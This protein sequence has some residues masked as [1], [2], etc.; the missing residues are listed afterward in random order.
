MNIISCDNC[1]VMLDAD[2]LDFPEDVWEYD[3]SVNPDLADWDEGVLYPKTLC[4]VCQ[5]Y[6]LSPTK[7]T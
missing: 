2:K 7:I 4:P 5:E 1:G 3:G 6:V